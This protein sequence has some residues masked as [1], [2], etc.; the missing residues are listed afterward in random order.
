MDKRIRKYYIF[1]IIEFAV[2]MLVALPRGLFAGLP[3]KDI[4][5][6]FSDCFF[7]SGLFFAGIGGLSWV[8]SLGGYDIIGYGR[9][10]LKSHLSRLKEQQ[11]SYYDYIIRKAKMRKPWLRETLSTGLIFIAISV[12]CIVLYYINQ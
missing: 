4:L 2:F 6:V 8:W 7:V 11:E 9:Y 1:I 10:T 5:A 3:Y 12:I